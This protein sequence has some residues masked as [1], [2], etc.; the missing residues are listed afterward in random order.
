MKS[1]KIPTINFLGSVKTEN[2]GNVI[3]DMAGCH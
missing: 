3:K 2:C 1:F